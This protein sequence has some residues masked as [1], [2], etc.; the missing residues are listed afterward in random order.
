VV[1]FGT[2]GVIPSVDNAAV[3][4]MLKTAGIS[5]IQI[6]FDAS[7]TADAH[8]MP[9]GGFRLAIV[10]CWNL[11]VGHQVR[12]ELRRLFSGGRSS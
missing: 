4:T 12:S 9:P 2:P 3:A 7:R 5:S 8:A 11:E 6:T 1:L 10:N